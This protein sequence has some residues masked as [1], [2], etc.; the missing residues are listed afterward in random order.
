M[1]F[2]TKAASFALA[3]ASS[4]AVAGA[5]QV[6][7]NTAGMFSGCGV[8]STA[9]SCVLNGGTGGTLNFIASGNQSIFSPVFGATLGTF[10][11]SG[12]AGNTYSLAGISFQLTI[13]QTMP[14]GG[15]AGLSSTLVGSFSQTPQGASGGPITLTFANPNAAIGQVR[16]TVS[17]NPTNIRLPNLDGSANTTD[18]AANINVVPEPSTYALMGAGL[19]GLVGMARRR[20]S[21]A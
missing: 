15:S 14:T 3:L 18:L 9:T 19:A 11:L 7:Y 8:G 16:Y 10:S 12:T 17:T 20:R 5:Q 13:N 6:M 2:T 21:I 4:A 1:R